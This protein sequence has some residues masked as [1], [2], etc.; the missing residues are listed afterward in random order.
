M[1]LQLL[2]KEEILALEPFLIDADDLI[3]DFKSQSELL[4][5]SEILFSDHQV[6]SVAYEDMVY[7]YDSSIRQVLRFLLPQKP[8][9]L[10]TFKFFFKHYTPI[11]ERRSYPSME[12]L[13]K[14]YDH[15]KHSLK[16]TE[17]SVFFED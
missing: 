17:W 6:L 4:S 3:E 10:H 5:Q 11:S 14:N 13:I 16:N 2:S 8:I 1:K 7:G 12:R 15:L 9:S